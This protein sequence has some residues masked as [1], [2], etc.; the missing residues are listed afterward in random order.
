MTRIHSILLVE[1]NPNDVELTLE[2]LSE[3]NLANDICVAP[4]GMSALDYLHNRGEYADRE[5]GNPAVIL[6]DLKLPKMTGI[7][8]LA[9]I[10]SDPDLRTIPV[11][12]LTSSKEERDLNKCY[13]LGV[14]AY[15]V[16][17]VSFGAF[18]EAIKNLGGFWALLNERPSGSVKKHIN[19][20]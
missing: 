3:Y 1:D 7:E 9:K 6:L 5:K 17:P 15:V 14:N 2:G 11:V 10:K 18:V 13:D 8:V 16:K 20:I 4:D 19:K 12:V